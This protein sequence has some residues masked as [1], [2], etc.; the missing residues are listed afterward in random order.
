VELTGT[1]DRDHEMLIANRTFESR[2][3]SW[4]VTPLVLDDGRT[5]AVV[6]G[7]VPRLWV[8]GSDTRDAGAPDGLVTVRGLA[9]SS[10]DGGKV[11]DDKVH[12]LPELNRMDANRFDEVTGLEFDTT[13][14][15]L[16]T[17]DPPN[18]ELPAPV[19]VRPLDEGPHQSY[20]IQWFLF[21]TGTVVVYYLILTRKKQEL[22]SGK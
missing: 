4:V 11:A 15:R 9:F 1:Y 5:V 19:P 12:G 16:Q 18:G 13:W 8:A 17:Q 10:I 3:G 21:S 6:R 20:A 22:E 7:W 2:A 14:V